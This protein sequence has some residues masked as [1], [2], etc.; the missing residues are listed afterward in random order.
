LAGESAWRKRLP[1]SAAEPATKK[2]RPSK[3]HISGKIREGGEALETG[4]EKELHR[5]LTRAAPIGAAIL[6]GTRSIERLVILGGRAGNQ[7][8]A[9]ELRSALLAGGSACPT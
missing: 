3:A 6:R 1:H 5:L 7:E 4:N 2:E 9:A 8:R